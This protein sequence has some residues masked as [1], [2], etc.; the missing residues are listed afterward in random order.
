M[1]Q[2]LEAIGGV[3]NQVGL[4]GFVLSP[5][6]LMLFLFLGLP[7]AYDLA[8]SREGYFREVAWFFTVPAVASLIGLI[9]WFVCLLASL[10]VP[11][12]QFERSGLVWL[13]GVGIPGFI[14][15]FMWTAARDPSEIFGS[16]QWL[17]TVLPSCRRQD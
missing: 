10:Q 9:V 2:T 15:S 1:S 8:S 17:V 14:A 12:G 13:G 16:P 5:I 6:W 7:L 11:G 4:I 3:V